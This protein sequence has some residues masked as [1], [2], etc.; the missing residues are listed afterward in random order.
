[1]LPRVW[2]LPRCGC[3]G[4]LLLLPATDPDSDPAPAARLGYHF[5]SGNAAADSDSDSAA[6][7]G[8]A[9]LMI[10]VACTHDKYRESLKG[11]NQ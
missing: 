9:L 6:L 3:S 2:Q 8:A 11:I 4:H 7:A 5:A 10:N 1:M